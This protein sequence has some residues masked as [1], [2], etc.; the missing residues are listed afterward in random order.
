MYADLRDHEGH[1]L[2]RID[3]ERWLLEIQKRGVKTLF[4]L[5]EILAPRS[6]KESDDERRTR[7]VRLEGVPAQRAR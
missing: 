7:D 4:D 5:R 6:A 3:Q 1:L 2:A